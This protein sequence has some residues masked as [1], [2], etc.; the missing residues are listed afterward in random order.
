MFRLGGGSRA[1][2]QSRILINPLNI[3]VLR[4][5]RRKIRAPSLKRL[6]YQST[7]RVKFSTKITQ[8]SA[9]N[10]EWSV[11]GSWLDQLV[12]A[13]VFVCSHPISLW[14]CTNFA[15]FCHANCYSPWWYR[16][17]DIC[18]DYSP[19]Y[20]NRKKQPTFNRPPTRESVFLR[21]FRI[22]RMREE[23]LGLVG[24]YGTVLI[25]WQIL[26]IPW[27]KQSFW[28]T[29]NDGLIRSCSTCTLE[30]STV[31]STR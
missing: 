24:F 25:N 1:A 16:S 9:W 15:L 13:E 17:D 4:K 12:K 21:F 6:N 27:E 14:R 11:R 22:S 28:S 29:R 31:R 30:P 3:Y 7:T 18:T 26:S 23:L 2:G 8:K 19:T 20:T 5:K 10:S